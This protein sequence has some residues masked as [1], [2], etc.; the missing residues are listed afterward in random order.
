[1]FE[2]E[3][4]CESEFSPSSQPI[5]TIGREDLNKFVGALASS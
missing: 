3:L 1:M 4:L 5:N 2:L